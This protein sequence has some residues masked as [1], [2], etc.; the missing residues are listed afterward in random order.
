MVNF[1]VCILYQDKKRIKKIEWGDFCGGPVA[2]SVLPMQEAQVWSLVR[3]LDPACC[4]WEPVQPN[5]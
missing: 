5:K 2:D 1:M 3:K 4:N